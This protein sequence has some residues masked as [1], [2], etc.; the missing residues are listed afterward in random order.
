MICPER[1]FRM[2]GGLSSLAFMQFCRFK[3]KIHP[4]FKDLDAFLNCYNA[5]PNLWLLHNTNQWSNVKQYIVDL[6]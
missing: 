5:L 1:N 4:E 3:H 6:W 2:I